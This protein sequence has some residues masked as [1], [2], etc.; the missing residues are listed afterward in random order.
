MVHN[1]KAMGEALYRKYR[2][3]SFDDVIGQDHVIKTLKNAIKNGKVSHGYLL[4]GPRGVGKTSVARIIAYT[5]NEIDS[6]SPD[7]SLDI[8][9]IDAASNRR[10]DEIR[11]LRDKVNIA[12]SAG[13]YKVY[14][15]DEVHM[16]T[17]EAFNALL[18]TLEEPP[19]H[20]VF[21]LATTEAHKL[22]ETIISRTQHFNFKL[23]PKS[24]S[25]EHLKQI[26]NKES[27]EIDDDALNLISHY[28]GG[29]F[30]DSISLLDQAS[31]VDGKINSDSIL[32]L[33]GA[34]SNDT[35]ISLLKTC[36]TG[37][38][39][40]LLSQIDEYRQNGSNPSKIAE[41]LLSILRSELKNTVDVEQEIGLMKQ[42]IE[43]PASYNPDQ[44][45]E[46]AVVSYALNFTQKSEDKKGTAHKPK[47]TQKPTDEKIQKSDIEKDATLAQ[48][49]TTK[50]TIKKSSF[51]NTIWDD[52]LAQI[53]SKHN[54]LHGI[55]RMAKA[56][57]NGDTLVLSVPYEFHK[58]R[59]L[60]KT[61]Q[62]IISSVVQ[63]ISGR[64]IAIEINVKKTDNIK[65][66]A[67]SE[68]DNSL[69]SL[70]VVA[71]VF[72]GGEVLDT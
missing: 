52:V 51:D 66:S 26:A 14:I 60:E 23:V 48:K 1:N 43:V 42:L 62:N 27:I 37:N 7:A 55:A 40:V 31:G 35:A 72:G 2:P 29:S 25:L 45:L 53:R 59:L 16:L 15:I 54:T 24:Q 18:K 28:G 64:D 19:K 70:D 50:E 61:N 71:K 34:P 10:I 3:K 44:A 33:V 12:P 20:V 58:K 30:R 56:D 9:E 6:G 49:K 68:E 22:P 32:Q 21:I 65:Q 39:A 4:S 36:Q 38:L 17:K 13:K 63:N 8:I 46:L 67:A 11:E 5:L 47:N 69:N 57:V 41:Q